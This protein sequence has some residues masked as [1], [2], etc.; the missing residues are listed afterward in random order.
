MYIDPDLVINKDN[1]K[2][3]ELN[4]I[5]SI[6]NGIVVSPVQCLECENCFCEL[7]IEKWKEKSE[8]SCP[9]RCKNPK[10]KSSRLIK[11]ILSNIKFKCQNGCNQEIPYLELEDHY[12]EKCPN[13]ITDYK[14]KY[15]ELKNKYLDLEKKY[16][17][18]EKQL[19]NYKHVNIN[20]I[21]NN[22]KSIYHRHNL[23]DY[24][25]D[26]S[27]W[28]CDICE[29]DYKAKTERRFRCDN[30]DFD[31]CIKCRILE[32]S[33]Y[34]FNVY[35]SNY[36]PH[37]LKEKNSNLSSIFVR[38]W[39]CEVCKKTYN[40][41]ENKKRFGC[42]KCKYNICDDCKIKEDNMINQLNF[43]MNNMNIEN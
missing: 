8:N 26:D 20:N 33:G 27:S 18:L 24:T 3:I 7:C 6:C 19:N 36:H 13:L 16:N 38:N 4:V 25:N 14:E 31:I 34:K 39:K 9:F 42:E 23:I 43:E 28:S 11:N 40:V 1:F 5:C 41:K 12:A 2:L 37:L 35:L 17:E 15:F 32:D 30:C 10:F 29:N 21:N 22:F